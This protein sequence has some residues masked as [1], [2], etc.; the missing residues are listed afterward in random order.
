M[1]NLKLRSRK[2]EPLTNIIV[3]DFC[4]W[5]SQ[6][7]IENQSTVPFDL[8]T[9]PEK[10]ATLELY[11][12]Q[13]L[14]QKSINSCCAIKPLIEQ[15]V[16]SKEFNRVLKNCNRKHSYRCEDYQN[17]DFDFYFCIMHCLEKKN[18]IDAFEDFVIRIYHEKKHYQSCNIT[19]KQL[20]SELQNSIKYNNYI[21]DTP[22]FMQLM[23]SSKVKIA[24][25]LN[26]LEWLQ[27]NQKQPSSVFKMPSAIFESLVDDYIREH[28]KGEKEK[29]KLLKSYMKSGFESVF[30]LLK[31]T[32]YRNPKDISEII[33]RYCSNQAEF[34]CIILPLSDKKSQKDYKDL[35][36]TKWKDLNEMSENYLDIFY[37]ETDYGKSGFDLAKRIELL[38]E[39]LR[40]KAPCIILWQHSIKYGQA[41]QLDEL[42]YDQMFYIIKHIVN[43]II[44]NKNLNEIVLEANKEVKR[45]QGLNYGTTMVEGDYIVGNNINKITVN[46]EKNNVSVKYNDSEPNILKY[47]DTAIQE[48]KL[49]KELNDEQKSKMCEVMEDAKSGIAEKSS[50]KIENAKNKFN[51]LKEF[52]IKIAPDLISALANITQIASFFGIGVQ[53]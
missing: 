18:F 43:Q 34:K 5:L 37:S 24:E 42:H 17:R 35:I 22:Q 48:I 11:A 26:F 20:V 40:K 44:L 14:S 8:V 13:F 27:Q 9:N 19:P 32:S 30:K 2:M 10:S 50:S 45:L 6:K 41:I 51:L 52:V 12:E 7:I 25:E 53:S 1:F 47:F 33:T 29:N 4:E 46:G 38:P 31:T 23:I 21:S 15:F 49:S 28:Q 16:I 3:L 36:K 39:A